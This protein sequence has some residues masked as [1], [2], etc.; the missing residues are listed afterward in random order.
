MRITRI[1]LLLFAMNYMKIL[2]T[3]QEKINK[4]DKEYVDKFYLLGV[5]GRI[6][7]EIFFFSEKIYLMR[8]NVD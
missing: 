8:W 4:V 2:N 5:D 3:F 7:R 6:D 1:I